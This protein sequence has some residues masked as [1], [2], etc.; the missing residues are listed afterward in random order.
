MALTSA[1]NQTLK[2]AIL[3]DPT[4]NAF[5]NTDDGNFDL[6]R[7]LSVE[8]QP[9]PVIVW[10]NNIPIQQVGKAMLSADVANVTA[11]NQS[12][13]QTLAWYAGGFFTGSADT[14][15][16]FADVF[17]AG[18]AAGTRTLL[19]AVWRRSALR[20]EAILVASGAGTDAS[21]STMGYEGVIT[22]P[23]VRTARNS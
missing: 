6:A 20:I 11:A 8:L 7:K 23:D 12:R 14:E 10:R 1:Q 13:L 16:G 4:L 22:M 9:G 17:S 5:P 15:A 3:A 21:P 18:P 19:H 2:A